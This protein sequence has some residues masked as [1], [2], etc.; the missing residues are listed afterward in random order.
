LWFNAA[1]GMKLAELRKR[2][3]EHGLAIRNHKGGYM[4][5]DRYGA[6]LAGEGFTLTL[7]DVEKFLRTWNI[8]KVQ[9]RLRK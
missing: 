4:V 7:D 5:V 3:L 8:K 2:A 9:Q 1:A 6:M